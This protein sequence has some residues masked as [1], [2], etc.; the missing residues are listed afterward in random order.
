[1]NT[2]LPNRPH[3][4]GSAGDANYA[5]IGSGYANFRRPDPVIF[6]HILAALGNAQH[7]VN[8][9]AGAGSYEPTD[10]TVTAIEPSE[11]MRAQRPPHLPRAVDASAEH[12]PFPDDTFDAALASFTV[13]QWRDLHRGLSELRRVTRGPVV[14]LTCDPALLHTFWLTHY[15]PRVIEV[16]A[17]RYPT[18]QHIAQT[19]RGTTNTTVL[20]IPRLCLDG[21]N[22]A[23]YARPEILLNPA[24]RSAC[25]AWSFLTESEVRAFEAALRADLQSGAWD[26]QFGHLRTQDTF[27]GSLVLIVNHPD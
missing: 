4:D 5:A 8:V 13:H 23:Y 26:R 9:G 2:P 10:R 25:S 3:A 15:A 14:I 11:T 7:I 21:F 22:E 19:L 6:Q 18:P 20:P 16:E 1:M 17:A 24:A 12:L 27:T